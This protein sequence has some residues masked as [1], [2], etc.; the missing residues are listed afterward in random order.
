MSKFAIA[1]TLLAIAALTAASGTATGAP[2]EQKPP[3]RAAVER[4]VREYLLRNPE[5]LVEMS[6]ALE[7]KAALSTQKKQREALAKLPK[8][9][10]LDPKVAFVTGPASA[11]K[12]VVEFFDYRCVHCKNSLPAM[13]KLVDDNQV[14]VVFIEHPILTTDSIVAARAAVAARRQEG[15]YVP[16]HFA[17]MKT[18][19]DLPLERILQVAKETGLDVTKLRRDMDGPAV[20][21]SVA[22][23]NAIAKKLYIDGTP[24]FIIGGEIIGG[25]LTV[26]EMQKLVRDAKS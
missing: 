22:A 19:G 3:D 15:K 24:T 11:S 10:L 4:I 12:T 16:F 9:A 17:L 21:Q 13:Q 18:S 5:I 20:T 7:A 1:A 2:A 6:A 23:S 26:E 8:D 14:R 25:E